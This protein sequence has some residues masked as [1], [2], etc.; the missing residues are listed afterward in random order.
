V[1]ALTDREREA[2]EVA[3][4]PHAT[5]IGPFVANRPSRLRWI[6]IGLAILLAL[7]MVWVL[8]HRHAGTGANRY[9]WNASSSS[10]DE[11]V[12]VAIATVA[13]G[14]IPVR[15]A[16]LGT[17]TPLATVTVKTQIAGQLQKIAFT[18]GQLV[19]EGD[20]LA[21]IDPRPYEAVLEQNRGNLRRDEALLVDAKLDLARYKDLIKED[22]VSA[23]QLD[24][25][26]ATVE[27]YEGTVEADKAQV[28]A[29]AVNLGY[30]HIVAPVTGR[31][32]LRQVDSGNYVTPSD[33]NGIVVIT[34]LQP[35]TA[36]FPVPEDDV[37]GIVQHLTQ[38]A[39]L[40]VEA[41]DRSNSKRLAVGK[42]LTLDNQID[43]TTGT[44][45]LRALFENR[46]GMLFPNQFVNI[47][48]EQ[49]V[50]HQQLIMPNAA[51]HRGA[52]NGVV[53][54]FVYVV[55][56]DHTVSVRPVTLGVL[57][58][59][60]IA[61][62]GGVAA[63]DVVVTEGGDRL[64]DGAQVVLPPATTEVADTGS[65]AAA[66]A[67]PAAAPQSPGASSAHASGSSSSQA[68]RK[69]RWRKS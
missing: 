24:Q 8:T 41:Y 63:G 57:D 48:L 13:K 37:S 4:A 42:L 66:P 58:G 2:G 44:V 18:E 55:K 22:A 62:T 10:S 1:E 69:W 14:E 34:Q 12:A 51:V 32:G 21:Q 61:V 6:L 52:P 68:R 3:R 31:V 54:T 40:P 64:R 39:A 43:T 23:Q 35:I 17:V 9:A 20:F 7:A 11:P 38:G 29:A 19:H 33:P 46:D 25:Q 49:E 16:A 26:K 45:K 67:L 15:I 56:A 36:I 28:A 47:E 30:C 5:D 65:S 50:L 59:E 27:Q 60:R 53:S